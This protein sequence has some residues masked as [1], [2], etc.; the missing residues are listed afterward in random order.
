[1]TSQDPVFICGALRSGSTLLHLMLDHHPNI[2]NP[3]EFDFLFDKVNDDGSFPLLS[4]YHEFLDSNRIFKSKNLAIDT[5]LS[6]PE[7]IRSFAA[8]LSEKQHIL[9]LN[10][11]RNF[12]RIPQLFPDAKYV[13]LLRDPR[14]VARSSIE[15]GWSGNVYFGADHWIDTELSWDNLIKIIPLQRQATVRFEQ[16]IANPESELAALCTFLGIPYD[17]GMLD[18][19]S[20]STY[21]KPDKSLV[22][23]WKNK[24]SQ[25]EIQQVEAKASELMGKRQYPLSGHPLI[26]IGFIEK[27]YLT[28]QN[29]LYRF[30]FGVKR[31]GFGLYVCDKLSKFPGLQQI[32]KKYVLLKNQIDRQHLK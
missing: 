13:H 24:Q 12:H 9:A 22:H 5:S 18:Y 15:M 4:D 29:K 16:L 26:T 20:H 7:L 3:G 11:H 31:Y 23:Q 17:K 19:P 14:D 10:V 30:K 27:I 2:K 6:Y 25:R 1:M 28:L 21:K 32:N 8:Q